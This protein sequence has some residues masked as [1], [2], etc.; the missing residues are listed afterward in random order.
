MSRKKEAKAKQ[1]TRQLI[2]IDEITDSGLKTGHGRLTFFAIKPTNLSVQPPEAVSNR[3]YAL[4]TVLKGQ[5]EIEMLAL[6]SKESFEDNKRYY[7]QRAAEEDLPVI[8]RL[9][10]A[11]AKSLDRLQIQMATCLLYTSDAADE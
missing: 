3:I 2:G 9:L 8:S 4:M 7:R 5:A 11:D 1:T 6:N 10:E